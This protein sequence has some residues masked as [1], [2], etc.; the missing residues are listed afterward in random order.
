MGWE[1][2]KRGGRYYTRS[3]RVNGAVVREYIGSGRVAE[4]VADTD[5]LERAQRRL[6]REEEKEELQAMLEEW[7]AQDAPFRDLDHLC[8]ALV[9][10]ALEGAG[11]HNHKGT[12][13][14]RRG[15]KKEG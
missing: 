11:Y 14:K 12:W 4:L 2:R 9:R 10:T 1:T 7:K 13:R 6:Q 15:E 8:G 3:R 5:A